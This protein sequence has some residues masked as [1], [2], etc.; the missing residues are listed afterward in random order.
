MKRCIL[1]GIF[2]ICFIAVDA[3]VWKAKWISSKVS[4]SDI[5]TFFAFRKQINIQQ[6]PQTAI[7]RIA[8][9]SKYWL[10]INGKPVIREG[11]LKRGPNVNNTYY[12][13]VDIAPWLTTGNNTIA[14]M[15]WYFGKEGISH[16][17]S[18]KCGLIFDCQTGTFDLLSDNTWQCKWLEAYQTAAAPLPNFRLSESSL[19]YDSQKELNNW[20][21]DFSIA[22]DQP[23]ESAAFGQPPWNVLEKRTIPQWK[24]YGV[25]NYISQTV[26]PDFNGNSLINC[27]LP[28]NAQINPY[29]K[30]DAPAPGLKIVVYTDNYSEFNGSGNG[31][32]FEYIT[33]KG[34]QEFEAPG[35][36]NGHIVYY[37]MPRNINILD[38]KFRETGYDAD[39]AGSFSCSDPFYN[40]YWQKAV[41]TMYV[42]L[43][44][45]YMDCPDRE[46]GQWPS[47]AVVE[48]GIAYHAL[49]PAVFPLSK[50]WFTEMLNWQKA[51][52]TLYGPV[53]GG[54][55]VDLP[56]QTLTALGIFGLWN[57]YMHS[58]DKDMLQSYYHAIQKYLQLWNISTDGLVVDRKG[59]DFWGD[60]TGNKDVRV[61][62]N[63]FYYLTLQC[64]Q[65][66][67]AVMGLTADSDNYLLQM[68]KFKDAFN[69]QFWNGVAYR[70]PLYTKATDDRSQALAVIARLAD[71]DKYPKIFDVL[72]SSWFASTYMEKYIMEALFVMG[73]G[74]F[75]LKRFKTRFDFMVNTNRFSTLWEDWTLDKGPDG[76]GTIN[77]GWAGGGL[78]VLSEYLCGIKPLE[79]GFSA[80]SLM[81]DPATIKS[82]SLRISTAKGLVE[83][84]YTQSVDSLSLQATVPNAS[85]CIVGIQ[86]R[87]DRILLNGKIIW[88]SGYYKNS[89]DMIP[90][91]TDSARIKFSLQSGK[92][93]IQAIAF[94]QADRQVVD[95]SNTLKKDT[96]LCIN[97]TLVL[98]NGSNKSLQW[99]KNDSLLMNSTHA[100][101]NV[102]DNGVYAVT[103]HTINGQTDTLGKYKVVMS[104]L[105]IAP[106][107]PLIQQ[108]TTNLIS[109]VD[110]N[111]QWYRFYIP[112]NSAIQKTY[113]PLNN[114]GYRVRTIA[115]NGCSAVSA[116]YKYFTD[117]LF[118]LDNDQFITLYPNPV[119][120][121]V[122]L[123][124]RLNTNKTVNVA[125]YNSL[126]IRLI[127]QENLSNGSR[128]STG[129][130]LRGIYSVVVTINGEDR[131]YTM[132]L[133]K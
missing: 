65:Q 72:K 121:Y 51:D 104:N 101:L 19:L 7:A 57:Y 109:S 68:K 49:S 2:L 62:A 39:F 130:L 31:L 77:H 50:K 11:G 133:I 71:P 14:V 91:G 94:Q 118:P 85:R 21:T 42:N 44:D 55:S 24:D 132:K 102:W 103:S 20:I 8:V 46:R 82:A 73:Q 43:R 119:T 98:Y 88:E 78:T 33:K 61:I 3:Q 9:D 124:Y 10:W 30:I 83:S 84:S 74:D 69:K 36:L 5:N 4:S 12:D 32:R 86:N 125:V 108:Q 99:Y 90:A 115:A 126:G 59:Y 75:A 112:I 131:R 64:L 17:N 27:K 97:D 66:S 40:T 122:N 92:W 29:F 76:Y 114:G 13:E 54:W 111:L 63:V 107:K 129:A 22:F 128:I 113:H 1:F 58:G 25:K 110:Q 34:V 105:N 81:P 67:A 28:Y 53:P 106:A 123:A 41:R 79:P 127:Y 117:V 60:R 96:V 87:Y 56:D 80:F 45:D 52:G 16:R 116:E 89:S 18:G 6:V 48:S 93:N 95:I 70:D 37:S 26:T 38:L 15:V 100:Y 120:D 23:E 47:D 35:W